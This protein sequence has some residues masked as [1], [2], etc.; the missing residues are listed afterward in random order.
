MI[1]YDELW[2]TMINYDKIPYFLNILNLL[3]TETS[4]ASDRWRATLTCP[5]DP[6]TVTYAARLARGGLF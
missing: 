3:E 1:N 2:L 4:G 6:D 5:G